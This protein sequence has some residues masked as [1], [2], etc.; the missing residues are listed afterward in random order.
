MNQKNINKSARG[1]F[2]SNNKASADNVDS[3]HMI[4]TTMIIKKIIITKY[5]NRIC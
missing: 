5:Q 4:L 3:H 1:T 2:N